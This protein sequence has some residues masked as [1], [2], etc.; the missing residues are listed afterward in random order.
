[1][2]RRDVV[3]AATGGIVLGT[4]PGSASGNGGGNERGQGN[5]PQNETGAGGAYE[6]WAL[7][8]GEGQNKIHVYEPHP[9]Q[10]DE[11]VKKQTIP[12]NP[13][14]IQTPHMVSF[15]SDDSYAA[16]AN[17]GSGNV[18]V[19]DTE[20]K[21][22]VETIDTGA[23]SHFA[24]FSPDDE[25]LLVDVI[26]E[27]EIVRVDANLKDEEFEIGDDIDITAKVEELVGDE[28]RYA[29]FEKD[30]GALRPICHDYTGEGHSYHT[31]GPSYHNAGL[32]ILNIETF[33][34]EAAF[35]PTEVPTN[36]GTIAHP[37]R[38]RFYLTAGLPSDPDAD[39]DEN[40]EAAEG[41]GEWYVFD[42]SEHL[43]INTDGSTVETKDDIDPEDIARDSDGV[44]A[45]GFWFAEPDDLELW[46]LNRETN[47][48][49]VVDPADD[50]LTGPGEDDEEGVETIDEFGPD[51]SP[52]PGGDSPDIMWSSPDDEYM[53]VTLR[54]PNPLSGDP[55][56]ATGVNPGVAVMDVETRERVNLLQPAGDN[57]D[58]DF[59][60]IGVRQ[61]DGASDD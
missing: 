60:G 31:L 35:P 54:G 6:V 34:L 9:R 17:T 42:T 3:K 38:E 32:V 16:V 30:D 49:I 37:E 52:A 43:P 13:H 58:A 4:V 21:R 29:E 1:M 50:T 45:H 33:E 18:A 15:S 36:C 20:T 8:Q 47:D 10:D 41:V 28:D 59:H 39:P 55:H 19:I 46:L 40:P 2:K 14:G 5:G 57:P 53:F 24:S 22:V 44:D 23:G 7:D 27:G 25:Y 26:G 11:F 12:L 51:T 56:A 48:G 61:V